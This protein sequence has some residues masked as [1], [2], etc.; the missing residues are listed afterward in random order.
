MEKKKLTKKEK[1]KL[2][3]LYLPGLRRAVITWNVRKS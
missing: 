3:S 2:I 1:E